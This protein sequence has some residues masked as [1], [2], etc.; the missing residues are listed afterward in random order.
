MLDIISNGFQRAAES[1]RGK[2]TLNEDNISG[3]LTEIQQSL[4][5][6]DVEYTVAKNFLASVKEKSLGEVV[7]LKAGRGDKRI[8]VSPSEH[9][10]NICKTEL[11]NL[12]GQ[13]LTELKLSSNLV[14]IMLVGLQGTGK[15][16]TAGKLA[17]FL[18]DQK[19]RKPLLVAADI[20]RPAAVEQLKVLGAKL[21]IPVYHSKG[22]SAPD[23]CEK[24]YKFASENGCDAVLFDTAGRLTI[25]DALMGELSDIKV[26]SKPD[27]ILLVCDAMMGQDA[28]TTAK[29][30]H[31]SLDLSGVVMTKLDG[32]AR[33]GA[34]LSIR[35][36]TGAPIKFLGTG[37]GLDKIE[38]FR[39]EGLASRILGLGDVVGLMGD[40]ERVAKEDQEEDA[41][42]M[43]QGKFTFNDFYEQISTIQKMGS[44]KD[45]VAKLPMQNMIPKEANIDDKELFNIRSMIDSM[46][47]K[48]RLAPDLINASRI[49]RIALGSGRSEKNVSGV[50]KKFMSMRKMMGKVGKN[51]GGGLMGKIPGMNK[52][53]Q[54]NQMRQ[55]SNNPGEL[56]SLLQGG[57][58]SFGTNAKAKVL[59]R[60]KLKKARKLAH[61]NK[62]KNRKK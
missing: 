41:I 54:L 40:F 61:K 9:F 38:V 16:T 33:G 46:T 34:A 11:E 51:M 3:A 32:D 17:K 35:A 24:A 12:M 37:E 15:T 45:I 13:G 5:E 23:I 30:F 48:E 52:L 56:Q 50:L 62:K 22:S 19:K 43:L 14:K 1:F 20:Y 55:L 21:N 53:S 29:S 47:K 18:R 8:K 26:R 28:V 49:R 6:A 25:D 36:V 58:A 4:L 39:P 7:R 57:G 60:S 27:H 44:L 10:V 59:D 2:T 31:E 42:R